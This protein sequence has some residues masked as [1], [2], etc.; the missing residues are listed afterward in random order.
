MAEFGP[1]GMLAHPRVGPAL[2]SPLEGIAGENLEGDSG[3]VELDP[4]LLEGIDQAI[5][6]LAIGPPHSGPRSWPRH[7]THP[8][9]V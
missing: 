8:A 9:A 7:A 6:S 2:D 3:P 4:D 1:R 5:E